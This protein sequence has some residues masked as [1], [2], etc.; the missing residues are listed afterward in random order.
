MIYLSTLRWYPNEYGYR[1]A[2]M[3]AGNIVEVL[4]FGFNKVTPRHMHR[5]LG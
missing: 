3:A 4:F 5:G 2:L 1:I